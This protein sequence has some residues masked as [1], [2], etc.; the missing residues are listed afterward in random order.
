MSK[1][2][3]EKAKEILKKHTTEPHLI[4]HAQAVSAA[5]G[6][7]ADY[8]NE[9]RDHWEAIGYLHDVDYEKYPD[10]HCHHVREL[11]E[12]EELDEEDI[13]AIISHGWG[14]CTDEFEPSTSLEKSLYTVDELTGVIIAYALMHPEGID[15]MEL[16]GLKKKFKDKSFAAGCNREVIKQGFQMLGLNPGTVMQLCIDGMTR[17]KKELGLEK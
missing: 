15:G 16:K 3:L 17:Y 5:M 6:A 11:L 8:Y 12:P 2:N 4:T 10:E 7:M 1:L 14:L 13:R 9:D